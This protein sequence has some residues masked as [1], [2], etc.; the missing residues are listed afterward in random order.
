MLGEFQTQTLRVLICVTKNSSFC[1]EEQSKGVRSKV[2]D[3]REK[4][5]SRPG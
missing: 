3:N 1:F 4:N 5:Q 2:K